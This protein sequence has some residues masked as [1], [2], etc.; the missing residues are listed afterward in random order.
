MFNIMK[1][2]R[3]KRVSPA[4]LSLCRVPSKDT[5]GTSDRWAALPHRKLWS[6]MVKSLAEHGYPLLDSPEIYVDPKGIDMVG[7][8]PLDKVQQYTLPDG[9]PLGSL[10]NWIVF[11]NNNGGSG[12]FRMAIG[13]EVWVCANGLVSGR[14][15]VRRKHTMGLDWKSAVDNFVRDIGV[16]ESVQLA[17][18]QRMVANEFTDEQAAHYFLE[19][20]RTRRL[21]VSIIDGAWE[22]WRHPQHDE[23]EHK[24]EWSAHNMITGAAKTSSIRAQRRALSV[25]W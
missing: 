4:G 1:D 15:M 21:P 8:V 16:Q 10:H 12:S 23:F 20:R 18:V 25:T 11:G 5:I 22:A 24:N 9:S 14:Y 19:A 3:Y 13:A 6:H 2:S 17:N 7:A